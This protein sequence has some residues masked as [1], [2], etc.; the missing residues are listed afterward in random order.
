MFL[1]LREGSNK[2]KIEE[3]I[4]NEENFW[5]LLIRM[6]SREQVEGL[7]LKQ[8]EETFFSKAGERKL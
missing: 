6:G 5:S 1:S 4:T 2:L 7:E 3:K 8:G